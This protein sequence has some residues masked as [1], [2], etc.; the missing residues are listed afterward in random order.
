MLISPV[1]ET[2]P[3]LG[4]LTNMSWPVEEGD[5]VAQLVIEKIES[6]TIVEVNVCVV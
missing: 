4:Q 3:A 6:P 5:R 2:M 1:S